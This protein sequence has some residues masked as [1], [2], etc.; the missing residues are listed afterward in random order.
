MHLIY[1]IAERG[2]ECFLVPDTFRMTYRFRGAV[3]IVTLRF[4]CNIF[5]AAPGADSKF[6]V[7]DT[8]LIF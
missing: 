4:L 8:D 5:L 6:L 2:Q 1:L 7:S 3:F